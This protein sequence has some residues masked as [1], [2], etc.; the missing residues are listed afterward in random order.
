[1]GAEINGK[2]CKCVYHGSCYQQGDLDWYLVLTLADL[3]DSVIDDQAMINKDPVQFNV[4]RN[5][6][7]LIVPFQCDICYFMNIERRLPVEGNAQDL[8][9]LLSIY[10]VILDSC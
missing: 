3:E 4:P 7:H 8:L 5:G 1:M 9:L 2:V 10:R 6:D